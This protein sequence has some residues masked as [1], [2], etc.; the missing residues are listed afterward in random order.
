MSLDLQTI[1]TYNNSAKQMAA[2]F[3]QYKGGTAK[4]EIDKAFLLAKERSPK[5]I[6]VGCGAGKEATEIVKRADQY[7]GFDPSIKLLEIARVHVPS[8]SFVQ[9]D[10]LSYSYPP[11]TDIVFAFAPLLHLNK[12]DFG[13]AC[14]KIS[15]S[16]R[17]GGI[18]CMSLKEANA[19]TEQIQKDEFGTR[20]FYLYSPKLAQELAGP[21]LKLI[22]QTHTTAG[23]KAKKWMSLFFIKDTLGQR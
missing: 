13:A 9:A 14:R 19:Y 2:H 15:D 16:L 23:I 17:V 7:E 12:E 20:R 4:E 6:E 1:Q 21:S 5:V 11:G 8:A 3:Q 22:D 18:L 10:A